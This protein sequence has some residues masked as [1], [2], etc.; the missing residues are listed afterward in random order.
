MTQR[1]PMFCAPKSKRKPSKPLFAAKINRIFPLAHSHKCN[2][3]YVNAESD[4]LVSSEKGGIAVEAY[5]SDEVL[6]GI[7]RAR[8]LSEQRSKRLRV[9]VDGE[10]YPVLRIWNSGF[11]VDAEAV[12]NLRGLVD[13]VD[14]AR[15]L[16]QCLIVRSETEGPTIHYEYK[17]H[18]PATDKPPV[19]Y[20]VDKEA[21]VALLR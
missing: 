10:E 14:G 20:V 13:L 1:S 2:I 4:P 11:S 16:A 17:R 21:P 19:D 3:I 5:I 15:H 8:Q 12:P 18:T 9:R 6:A 7:K